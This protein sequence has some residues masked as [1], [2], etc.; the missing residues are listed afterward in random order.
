MKIIRNAISYQ[1][2]LLGGRPTAQEFK[3]IS[4]GNYRTVIDLRSFAETGVEDDRKLIEK[5]GMTAINIEVA[6]AKGLTKEAAALLHEALSSAEGPIVVCCVSGN[7]VGALLSL[8]AFWI[9]GK[10]AEESMM[11]GKRAGLLGLESTVRGILES[12]AEKESG[13]AAQTDF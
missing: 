10:T 11:V 6:G 3:K 2:M 4:E 13:S 7:R 12:D 1:G 9:Q 8:R 5:F